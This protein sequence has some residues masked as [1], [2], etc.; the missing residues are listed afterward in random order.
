MY[1]TF[2]GELSVNYYTWFSFKFEYKEKNYYTKFFLQAR[3]ETDIIGNIC[4]SQEHW[5]IEIERNG[6]FSSN[7]LLTVR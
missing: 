7:I 6:H 3:L 1:D 5:T 4:N 2:G